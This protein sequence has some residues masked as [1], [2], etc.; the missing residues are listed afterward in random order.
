MKV[1]NF[2]LISLL[3]V[4]KPDPNEFVTLGS[5]KVLNPCLTG[6]ALLTRDTNARA[7]RIEA[8]AMVPAFN[9]IAYDTTLGQG[10][11]PVRAL[12][13]QCCGC[14]VRGSEQNDVLT[15]ERSR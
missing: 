5:G 1:W 3:W 2:S 6:G 12:V 13:Q 10:S 4:A 9:D 8:H 15:E 7:T 14:A 11:K